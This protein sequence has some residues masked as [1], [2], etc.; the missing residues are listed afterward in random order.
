MTVPCLIE[1]YQSE[2]V[3][4][5]GRYRGHHVDVDEVEEASDIVALARSLVD[6]RRAH[7]LRE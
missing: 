2:L 4:R 6:Q 3:P 7:P 5:G 1:V